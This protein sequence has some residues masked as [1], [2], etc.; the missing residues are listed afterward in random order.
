MT[1]RN[2]EGFTLLEVLVSFV[3]LSGA[4]ILAF[5]IGNTSLK[6]LQIARDRSHEFEVVEGELARQLAQSQFSEGTLRGITQGISWHIT[7]TALSAESH[8]LFLRHP[9]LV[10]AFGQ[11]EAPLIETITLARDNP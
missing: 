4:I 6:G 1:L 11:G 9:L 8:Q 3:I 7:S 2:S 10:K 5:Q